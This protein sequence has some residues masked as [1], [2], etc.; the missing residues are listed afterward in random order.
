LPSRTTF[1]LR[2]I[3]RAGAQRLLLRLERIEAGEQGW[4]GTARALERLHPSRFA[5]PEAQFA[6]QINVNTGRPRGS[7]II[8]DP[9]A[10]QALSD[11]YDR[12]MVTKEQRQNSPQTL[13]KATYSPSQ[14]RLGGTRS[15]FDAHHAATGESC[16]YDAMRADVSSIES[17]GDPGSHSGATSG[18]WFDSAG[19]SGDSGGG[20][21]G[22]GG[23]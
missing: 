15:D 22:G 10:L 16:N 3:K 23:D 12:E 1:R 17:S 7:G 13:S 8:L 2:A 11:A 4:Q 14:V 5:R 6:Q 9:E 19:D 18:G 20:D 21:C